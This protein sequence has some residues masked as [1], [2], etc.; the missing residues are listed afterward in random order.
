MCACACLLQG[1]LFLSFVLLHLLLP[2]CALYFSFVCFRSVVFVVGVR[3]G[4]SVYVSISVFVCVAAVLTLFS[5]LEPADRGL[6]PLLVRLKTHR[7]SAYRSHMSES[8]E[9]GG[10]RCM[11]YKSLSARPICTR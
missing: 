6:P 5:G 11:T 2:V 9:A 3:L 7:L 4:E 10:A 8:F 1:L